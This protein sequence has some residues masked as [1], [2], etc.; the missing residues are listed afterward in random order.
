MCLLSNMELCQSISTNGYFTIEDG[1]NTSYISTLFI[2]LFY[3]RSMIERCLLLENNSRTLNGLYL[4]KLIQT[5]FIEP[6]R[7]NT[8]ITSAMLNEIRLSMYTLGWKISQ[9]IDEMCEEHD[10]IEL[11]Q[12]LYK[13]INVVPVETQS[14]EKIK[15]DGYITFPEICDNVQNSYNKW[16]VENKI[17]NIPIFIIFKINSIS[18][19]FKINKRI[20]LFSTSHPYHFINWAFHGLFYKNKK[21]YNTIV[22]KNNILYTFEQNTIPA[23]KKLNEPTLHNIQNKEI[24]IIYR[25]EPTI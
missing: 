25:K 18:T 13:L 15:H 6:L 3:E 5:N 7:N 16:A 8:C 4:Q 1:Y 10:S 22:E 9:N 14:N 23:I 12:F 11:L 2:V 20:K 19:S 17:T 21:H 24:F